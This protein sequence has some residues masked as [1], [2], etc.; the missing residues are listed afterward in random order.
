MIDTHH[1][2]CLKWL[3]SL[4]SATADAVVADP[5]Y[6]VS[7]AGS[8][9]KGQRGMGSRRLNFFEGDDDWRTMRSFVV[10]VVEESIRVMTERASAYWWC[11]HRC[12]GDIVDAFEARGYST[13]ML[14]WRKTA[15]A[16]SPPAA[17]W[18]QAVEL[19]VYAYPPRRTWNHENHGPHNVIEAD[20]MRHGQ[21][22]KVDHPT[23]KPVEVIYPLIEA[24][25]RPG[26]LVVDPRRKLEI[27]GVDFASREPN[28]V[29]DAGAVLACCNGGG[30]NTCGS[31]KG[32]LCPP[33]VVCDPFAGSGSLL[34]AAKLVGRRAIGVEME[35][36]YCRKA[37]ESLRQR[38]PPFAP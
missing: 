13:R 4:D 5:P 22:G 19:C 15:P 17:G 38:T 11:G 37:A 12:V 3:R 16:P 30:M 29:F 2:D 24:S 14:V 21:P 7:I 33:G 34:R 20:S 27:P 26:D 6:A 23:Q 10:S 9:H 32:A 28:Q 1:G 25:T 36:D 35:E 31:L 18:T 8:V